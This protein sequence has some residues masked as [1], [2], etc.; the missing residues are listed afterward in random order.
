[1]CSLNPLNIE[2]SKIFKKKTTT[3]KH[4]NNNKNNLHSTPN[5]NVQTVS[6]NAWTCINL[7]AVVVVVVVVSI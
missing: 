7:I 5:S 4:N 2:E 3:T 1:M 6:Q